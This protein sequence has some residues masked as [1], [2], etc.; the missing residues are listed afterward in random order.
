M[1]DLNKSTKDYTIFV[2]IAAF[3]ETYI[4]STL[5][6]ALKNADHPDRLHFGI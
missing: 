4:K 2:S 5:D 1:I 6:E 3:N